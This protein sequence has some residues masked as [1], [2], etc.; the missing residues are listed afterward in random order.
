MTRSITPAIE[1]GKHDKLHRREA[2]IE[3]ATR[4]FAEKGYECAT[5]REI[6]DRALCSEG[7]IHRYFGGK[8][9]LLL[10]I[11]ER[12]TQEA[13][14]VIN[15]EV[16][17]PD[18]LL[19]ELD[20]VMTWWLDY[21]WKNRD[22]LR[23]SVAQAIVDPEI[24]RIVG[25]ILT[26]QRTAIFRD[27]LLRHQRAGRIA[28]DVDIDAAAEGMGGVTFS[29]GFFEQVVFARDRED[30]RRR[31]SELASVMVRGIAS[32]GRQGRQ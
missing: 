5:T 4:V 22:F 7:L 3:A 20:H 25:T 27:M 9:G 14:D 19:V 31:V 2:F 28:P 24:G 23:V 12:K 6:A 8:R 1:R 26:K 17:E 29:A 10:A 21:A 16:P 18:D 15:A 32:C 13:R 11:L 30:V